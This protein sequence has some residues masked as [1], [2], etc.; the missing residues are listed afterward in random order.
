MFAAY[1]L[2]ALTFYLIS[3]VPSSLG[4]EE[5]GELKKSLLNLLT[6]NRDDSIRIYNNSYSSA[7]FEKDISQ[8]RK[9]R[10]SVTRRI[11]L[12]PKYRLCCCKRSRTTVS[13]S[14]ASTLEGSTAQDGST[15][16]TSVEALFRVDKKRSKIS[17]RLTNSK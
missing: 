10:Y 4:S 5:D 15:E 14:T 17:R 3:C 7:T 12:I 2:M 8:N 13:P 9:K 1:I 6:E 11:I 16:S